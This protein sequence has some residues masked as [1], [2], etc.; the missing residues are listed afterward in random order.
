VYSVSA[1]GVSSTLALVF[2][3]IE[4]LEFE[5]ELEFDVLSDEQP[6]IV[7]ASANAD[8]PT[9]SLIRTFVSLPQII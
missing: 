1:A 9:I 5:F 7:K 8:A 3:L 2:E 6:A 4:T